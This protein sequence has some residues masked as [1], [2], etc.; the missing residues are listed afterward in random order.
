MDKKA[1][2]ETWDEG[3]AR[4]VEKRPRVI[5]RIPPDRRKSRNLLL[6][7]TALASSL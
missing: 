1:A 4:Q 7:E 6:R 2:E 5:V 3:L